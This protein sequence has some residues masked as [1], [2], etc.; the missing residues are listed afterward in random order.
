MPRHRRRAVP[1]PWRRRPG[2]R[3]QPSSHSKSWSRPEPR[4]PRST[5]TQRKA[6][7]LTREKT[8][9]HPSKSFGRHPYFPHSNAPCG[10]PQRANSEPSAMRTQNCPG[11]DSQQPPSPKLKDVPDAPRWRKVSV[12]GP[13]RE[14]CSQL[15]TDLVSNDGWPTDAPNNAAEVVT[16]IQGLAGDVS[17]FQVG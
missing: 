8:R 4:R 17:H 2:H 9:R 10:H 1:R 6:Q 12:P 15:P 14:V 16:P 7:R 5:P 11:G 13:L 3:T